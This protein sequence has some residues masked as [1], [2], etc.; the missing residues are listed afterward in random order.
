MILVENLTKAFGPKTAVNGVSFKVERGE[1]L[2][3]LG[4]NGAGKSTTMRMITGYIPPTARSRR[5][6]RLRRRRPADRGEAPDRLPARVGAVVPRD[7]GAGVPRLRRRDARH[8]RRRQ[9]E[10][11]APRGRDLLPRLGAAPDDR[12]L[13]EGLPPPHLPRAGADPRPRGPDHG[14]ADRRA[15]SQPEARGADL[16][17]P[18]GRDE[19]DRL[20]DPHPRRG[21]GGVHARDHH[22]PRRDRR[23]RDAGGAEGALG[24]RRRGADDGAAARAPRR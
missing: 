12:H 19:G 2:G 8:A 13:V 22:R 6:L 18:D 15:R 7:D 3:F 16:D 11:R 23:E 1:V 24:P 17:P 5:G 4:P 20:L 21:R 14:R 9:E 10:G